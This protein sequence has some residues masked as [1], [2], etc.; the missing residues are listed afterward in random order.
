MKGWLSGKKPEDLRFEWSS[1]EAVVNVAEPVVI[2]LQNVV[3]GNT[4]QRLAEERNLAFSSAVL[5]ADS[6]TLDTVVADNW[7]ICFVQDVNASVIIELVVSP[8][9]RGAD[10]AWVSLVTKDVVPS[11]KVL[12]DVKLWDSFKLWALAKRISSTGSAR[13]SNNSE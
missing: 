6:L 9:A 1:L 13:K 2:Q 4:S 5:I 7:V 12:V 8:Q 10:L 3:V 11:S